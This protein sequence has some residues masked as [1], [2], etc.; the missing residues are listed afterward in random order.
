[1]KRILWDVDTQVDFVASADGKL[2]VPDATDAVPAMARL[3]A[4][5]RAAGIPHVAS[6]DDHEL[7]DAEIS[8][9]ARLLDDVSAALPARHA[10][11]RED[12]RRR[13][14]D[15]P[16]PLALTEVPEHWLQ[17]PR[18]PAPEEA[19]RRLHEPERRA[20][21][22]PARPRRGDRLRRRHR[23]LRRAAIRGLLARGRAVTFVEEASR[24]LDEARTA[25]CVAAWRE[26]GVRFASVGRSRRRALGLALSCRWELDDARL[27]PLEVH[28][29]LR[30]DVAARRVLPAHV[31]R[32]LAALADGQADAARQA[33]GDHARAPIVGRD[34][35]GRRRPRR[36]EGG[37]AGDR[38]LPAQPGALRV[39]RRAR[40]EGHPLP[41]AA[42]HRQDAR[43][44][45][46]RERVG[47]ALLRAERLGVRRDVRRPRRCAHPQALRR[48][49]Q[50][51][52][53]DRLHR[54]ARRG[55]PGAQRPLVQP[56][57]GPD[58]QPAARR[59]RRLRPARPGGRDGR[60]EPPA[61]SRPG[62]A[63]PRPLRPSDLHPAAR[64][65][66]PARDPRRAH[67]RQA[68]RR[69]RRP[70]VRR[71]PDRRADRRRSREHLQR[72]RD[73]R[74]PPEPRRRSRRPTST[75]RSSAS[76]PACSSV[77]S[78][79]TR[80]S[81]SSPTTRAATRSSRI[82]SAT[83]RR[84]RRSSRAARRSATCS[85]CRKRSATSRRRR[86]CSTGW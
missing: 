81:A 35:G 21:A 55:R 52:A 26:G 15:D 32:R 75:T 84:R 41:R 86:S 36:G 56:R 29:G 7:T 50:E 28:F 43:G 72:G 34:V 18:V 66:G 64:P 73:R 58:A 78:S 70:R 67:A 11:R 17:G 45:G 82:S 10:R 62:A 13:A 23:R 63:A 30:P 80:R 42:R 5:A 27:R 38:R 9:D 46:D 47:R 33:D 22:R 3:V 51:R 57:A 25:A 8:E 77:A 59:A 48:G 31:R 20:P 60:V 69:R 68:A 76:S 24:G 65:E 12:R 71:A 61:G 14:Q 1:M 40:P 19:F 2:A 53:V 44:E 49:A 39:A 74:R 37:A 6:A 4:A 85:T 83:S 54:R 16:V 79:P